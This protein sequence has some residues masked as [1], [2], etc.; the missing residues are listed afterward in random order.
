MSKFAKQKL[1]QH[2]QH[3]L[4]TMINDN[5]FKRYFGD[6]VSKKII[7][8]SDLNKY[9]NINQLLPNDTDYRIILTENQPNVGH[10]CAVLKYKNIIEWWDSYGVKPD[11]EFKY[12][13][14][15]VRNALGQ[16]GNRLSQLLK[17]KS[18]NQQVYYNK[19]RFQ[20]GADG[21]NTCGRWTI[22]R[23]LSMLCGWELDDFID[24]V[25]EKSAE[26]GKPF[27][28]LVCDWIK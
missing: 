4:E 1:M 26:T 9:S 17:T 10:W 12:I 25:E 5:D 11:G 6:D 23:V 21:I 19:K 7:K 22:A 2:Y 3:L 14:S 20:S 16:G 27:D 24:K 8:Y 28:I 15:S 13:P 18:P